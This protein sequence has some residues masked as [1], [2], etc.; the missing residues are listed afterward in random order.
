LNETNNTFPVDPNRSPDDRALPDD[1]SLNMFSK[2]V[3]MM[4]SLLEEVDEL[5]SRA[6]H[7]AEKDPKAPVSDDYWTRLKSACHQ[8]RQICPELQN[9]VP[10]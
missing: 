1:D 10:E 5:L 7:L 2:D 4:R 9:V 8:A 6:R 3:R